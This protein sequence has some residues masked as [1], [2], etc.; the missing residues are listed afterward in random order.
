MMKKE[1]SGLGMV[2][3]PEEED[4]RPAAVLDATEPLSKAVSLIV[5]KK[6][7]CVVVYQGGKYKGIIESKTLKSF[8]KGE[9][10]VGSIAVKAPMLKSSMP[11]EMLTNLFFHNPF[12]SLPVFDSEGIDVVGSVD[13]YSLLNAMIEGGIIPKIPVTAIMTSPVL[14]VEE[15]ATI[16]EAQSIMKK[17]KVSRLVVTKNDLIA[18]VLS[19]RDLTRIYSTPKKVRL[20]HA[21]E[22]SKQESAPITSFMNTHVLTV[23]ESASVS[24]TLSIMLSNKIGSVVVEKNKWPVGIVSIKDILEFAIPKEDENIIISGLDVKNKGLADDIKRECDARIKKIS[25]LFTV[26]Y[27]AVHVKQSDTQ[28]SVR[29]RISLAGKVMHVHKMKPSKQWDLMQAV[30]SSLDQAEKMIMETKKPQEKFVKKKTSRVKR[31]KAKQELY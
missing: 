31:E 16:A 1:I 25:K 28:L 27:V 23:G 8:S 10:K 2:V 17:N 18:G 21:L 7:P 26:D 5:E 6:I 14:T 11:L 19:T 3:Y 15:S 22:R 29:L 20:P 30:I 4:L 12:T 24:D 13:R 9:S